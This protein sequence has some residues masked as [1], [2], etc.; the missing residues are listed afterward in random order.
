MVVVAT[1]ELER[2]RVVSCSLA[3]RFCDFRRDL[4]GVVGGFFHC[5]MIVLVFVEINVEV[6]CI[7]RLQEPLY[8][9][10]RNRARSARFSLLTRQGH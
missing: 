10:G 7:S 4:L 5:K 2:I 1:G 8:N 3:E 6:S 9:F